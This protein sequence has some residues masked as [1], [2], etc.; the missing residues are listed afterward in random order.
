MEKV[1]RIKKL[2][3]KL[4]VLT[5]KHEER[6]MCLD[7][8][9]NAHI[10]CIISNIPSQQYG[11][12]LENYICKKFNYTKN[13][14]SDSNGDLSKDGFTLEI[15]VS[16]GGSKY[17][18]YNFVQI[19]P[20][21]K[22]DFYILT[23]YNVSIENAENEGELFIFKIPNHKMQSLLLKYGNYAH[24]SVKIHGTIT[25]ESL[26]DNDNKKEYALRCTINDKCWKSLIPFR[27][28]ENDL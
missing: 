24:G 25:N 14:A 21:H 4:K 7:T 3:E 26:N 1:E 23:A 5:I 8:L 13:K 9:K 27:I 16:F 10:Y 12:L 22:C 28:T 20:S 18:R 17:K 2:K 6:I 19:R 15:K 11:C